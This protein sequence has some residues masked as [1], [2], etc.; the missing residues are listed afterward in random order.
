MR[1]LLKDEVSDWLH[2]WMAASSLNIKGNKA[3]IKNVVLANQSKYGHTYNFMLLMH[4]KLPASLV[5]AF[6]IFCKF[7]TVFRKTN[8]TARKLIFAYA[9]DYA[10]KQEDANANKEKEARFTRRRSVGLA[11]NLTAASSLDTKQ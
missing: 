3:I 10:F 5:Y 2:I 1:V 4:L 7:V 9:R 6:P 11:S 8:R